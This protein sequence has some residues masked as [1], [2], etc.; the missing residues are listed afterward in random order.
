MLFFWIFKGE[1]VKM[2]VVMIS[3]NDGT[4]LKEFLFSELKDL[5]NNEDKKV[6]VSITFNKVILLIL[7]ANWFAFAW[8][9]L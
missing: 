7:S 6:F 9:N 8:F 2:P 3:K 5:T 4:L 1:K